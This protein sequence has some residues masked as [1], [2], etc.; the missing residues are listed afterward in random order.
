MKKLLAI[1]VLTSLTIGR[2]EALLTTRGA[3]S[4][5]KEKPSITGTA[6]PGKVEVVGPQGGGGVTAEQSS[7]ENPV[8]SKSPTAFGDCVNPANC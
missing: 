2:A 1:L 8:E 6:Q 5:P 4:Q 3:V 7:T